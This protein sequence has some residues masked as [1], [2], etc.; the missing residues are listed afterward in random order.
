MSAKHFKY[1]GFIT[2]LYITLQLA[3]DVCAGKII[4]IA[5][6]PVS[7]TVL[8]FPVTYIFSDILTEVYGY[9]NARNVLWTVMIASVLAG[10][11]YI[12]VV[13]IPPSKF[14]DAN[15]AYTRVLGQVP[16]ILIGGWIAVLVGDITNNY[17]MAKMK[18][19]TNGRFLWTRT[20]GS[21]IAGQ[22]VNTVIFYAIGLYGILDTQVLI[23]SILSGWVLKVIV[24][25]I[26][27]P[28]TY[29]VT[30][31]LKKIESVDYYDTDTDFN[32]FKY[33]PPF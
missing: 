28:L 10:L 23:I 5:S 8:F 15:A 27:T 25:I 6:F 26:F 9:K 20:V 31:K 19:W 30:N 33:T 17:V 1:L 3:S 14:F 24:E 7:V 13:V 12:L 11:I 29:V 22:F 21:T 18:I 4:S 2:C 16:R 32:P